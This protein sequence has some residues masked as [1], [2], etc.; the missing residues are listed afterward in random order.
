MRDCSFEHQK[1]KANKKRL[2]ADIEKDQ[3]GAFLA[4]LKVQ[5]VT[6]AEWLKEAITAEIKAHGGPT[7]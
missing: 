4:L 6:Y 2:G 7:Q 3:A 5:G 1:R